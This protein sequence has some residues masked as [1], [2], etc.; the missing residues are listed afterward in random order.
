[1]VLDYN[2]R[3]LLSD[4]LAVSDW[5]TIGR[6]ANIIAFLQATVETLQARVTELETR[7]AVTAIR[8]PTPADML[9][10]ALS[11]RNLPDAYGR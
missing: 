11:A 7:D 8:P 2:G 5:Q 6:Q 10:N 3:G 1:M 4:C 9:A